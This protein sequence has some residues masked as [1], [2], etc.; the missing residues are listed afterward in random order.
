MTRM[1]DSRSVPP[2]APVCNPLQSHGGSPLARA[3][4]AGRSAL[5]IAGAPLL[6]LLCAMLV[7]CVIPPSLRPEDDAGAPANSPPAIVSV[8]G[9]TALTEPGPVVLEQGSTAG[10]LVVTLFDTDLGDTLYVR[11]FVDYNAP[12]RLPPRV[13]CN[14]SPNGNAMRPATCNVSGLCVTADIGVQRDLSIVVSDR[15]PADFGMDPQA[16]PSPGLSTDRFY[17]L[18]CQPPQTP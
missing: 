4:Q 5:A 6:I 13:I 7:G 18:Q 2:A 9:G 8:S 12:D 10:N 16:V 17:F 11:F 3:V 15:L 14:A 1:S